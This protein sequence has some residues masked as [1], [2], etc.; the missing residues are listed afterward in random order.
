MFSISTVAGE[1]YID[2]NGDFAI[3]EDA[4]QIN[5][6]FVND[7]EMDITITTPE[8]GGDITDP[9]GDEDIT[10]SNPSVEVTNGG[11]HISASIK[12]EG[13]DAAQVKISKANTRRPDT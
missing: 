7:L 2:K 13:A 9:G 8:G 10:F 1:G 4:T 6:G 11:K 3:G 12:A 5:T